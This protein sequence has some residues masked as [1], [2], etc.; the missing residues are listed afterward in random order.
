ME[1][2]DEDWDVLEPELDPEAHMLCAAMWSRDTEL[3]D[4]LVCNMRAEDFGTPFYSQVFACLASAIEAG[5][6]HDP[7]SLA[8]QLARVGR[9]ASSASVHSALRTIATLGTPPEALAHHAVDV[10]EAAYRRTYFTL[11]TKVQEIAEL[12]HTEALFEL[13]ILEGR[14]QR[15]ESVRLHTIQSGPARGKNDE[16]TMKE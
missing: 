2:M 10:A 6:P 5:H 12:A 15:A 8:A 13:L 9:S 4:F 16:E 14:A 7:A 3:L 1:P 11:A